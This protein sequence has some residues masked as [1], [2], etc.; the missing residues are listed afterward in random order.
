MKL[1]VVGCNHHN[2]R[3]EVREKLAFTP[4]QCEQALDQLRMQFPGTE[5]VLI[6]TC[7]RVDLYTA[8]QGT[9]HEPSHQQL[10]EFLA[11]FHGFEAYEIFDDLFERTGEDA[12]RHL[13]TVAASLDS[14]VVGEAQILSHVRQAYQVAADRDCAGP[15]THSIF[16]RALN[17]AKR[18]AT[19]TTI[20]QNRVSIPSV[21]VADYAKGV[22]E[23]FDDKHVLVIGAGEMAEET[24]RYLTD[25]GARRVTVVNRNRP[26]AEALAGRF[27]GVARDWD[28]LDSLLVQADL[29][30]STTGA[31]E[32]IMT[33]DR[34]APIHARRQQRVLLILDLAVPRDFE[35][36]VGDEDLIGFYLLSV[37]DL[38]EACRRNRLAR[39]AALP[40]AVAI[41]DEETGRFMADLNHRAT[42]PVIRRLKQDWQRIK[43]DELARLLGKL[44]DDLDDRARDDIRQSFDR[45]INKLLHPPLE[46]LR[47]EAAGGVPHALVEAL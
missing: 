43:D 4:A 36:A 45:L 1:A 24:L 17:V 19:E 8:A 15:L 27:S 18:V 38:T 37:D 22:F 30:I 20:N 13:F 29:V 10:A 6:S 44:P 16:Q 34:F 11:R 7:N 46:S 5:A 35:P 12:V 33:L 32:P 21:A 14:M 31:T 47:D 3:V 28:E 23:R 42:S 2:A 9:S 25:E 40:R 41:I 39:E 26:R